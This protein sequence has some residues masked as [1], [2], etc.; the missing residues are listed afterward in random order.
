MCKLFFALFLLISG[1]V[2]ASPVNSMIGAEGIEISE[3]TGDIIPIEYLQSTGTQYI[4]LPCYIPISPKTAPAIS[5]D[6]KF[7]YNASRSLFGCFYGSR[8]YF[9]VYLSV[10]R[11]KLIDFGNSSKCEKTN[12]FDD[13]HILTIVPSLGLI[14]EDNDPQFY[15]FNNLNQSSQWFCLF[16]RYNTSTG[17]VESQARNAKIYLFQMMDSTGEELIYDLIPVRIGD[18]G[19]MYDRISGELFGNEGTGAFVLGPDL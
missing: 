5:I 8:G 2:I 4:L 13:R 10:R 7:P 19:F 18:D 1:I 12:G 14:D 6:Y 16:G 3:E 15:A 9:L 11:T 17:L